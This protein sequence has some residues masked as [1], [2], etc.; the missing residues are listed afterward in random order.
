MI[1]GQVEHIEEFSCLI[2]FFQNIFR[3]DISSVNE[4]FFIMCHSIAGV[5]W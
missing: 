1:N 2:F 5:L 3:F 4:T